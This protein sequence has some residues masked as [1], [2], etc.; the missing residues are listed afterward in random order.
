MIIRNAMEKYKFSILM[1][2][3]FQLFHSLEIGIRAD[4]FYSRNGIPI[5][6]HCPLRESE[7]QVMFLRV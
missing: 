5:V 2:F 1:I 4:T 3:L 6:S 7:Q